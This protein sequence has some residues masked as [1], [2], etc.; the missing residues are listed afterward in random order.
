MA[1][2][3]REIKDIDQRIQ[4]TVSGFVR[5]IMNVTDNDTIPSIVVAICILYYHVK[6]YFTSHGPHIELS[7]NNSVAS[8]VH[9]KNDSYY[10]LAFGNIKIT[11]NANC[12]YQL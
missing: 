11:P 4:D 12:I 3:F 1:D 5:Q 6:E 7:D 8:V 10:D 9:T 2:N